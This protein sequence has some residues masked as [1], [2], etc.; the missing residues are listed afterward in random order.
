MPRLPLAPPLMPDEALSSWV[1]RIAA[2]YD[3]YPDVL[4]RHL[5]ANTADTAG[6]VQRLDHQ[7]VPPLEAALVEATGQPADSFAE[8]RFTR[9]MTSPP[10]AW[11]RIKPAW[12]PLCAIRDVAAFGEVYSRG[13]WQLGGVLWCAEHK[14]LLIAECP[15]CFHQVDYQPI[16]GRLRLWCWNCETG[17]D[18]ALK[19]NRIPFW[20]YGT[21]QQRRSC[22]AVTLSDEAPALLLRVQTD[23]LGMLAGKPPR[24]PWSRSLKW[25]RVF[26]VLRRLVFAMLGPLWERTYQVSPIQRTNSGRWSLSETWTPGSLPPEIAAPALLAAVTFLAAESGTRLAGLTWNRQLLIAGEDEAITAETLL[27]HLDT[28]NTGLVRDLFAPRRSRPFALLL[29]A[30]D[31][32]RRGRGPAREATRRRAGLGGAQ[33]REREAGQRRSLTGEML[34]SQR[35]LPLP[36]RNPANRFSFGRLI[37]D[38]APPPAPRKPRE[39]WQEAVAV[40]VVC[41]WEPRNGDILAPQGDWIPDLLRNRYIRLW[42]FRHRHRGA[43]YLITTL[44]DAIDTARDLNRDIVLPEVSAEPIVSPPP[45]KPAVGFPD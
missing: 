24:G 2:R 42:I 31:A 32:D 39:T 45:V 8:H 37:E 40:Y 41:G 7:A 15:R 44:A 16:N 33:R 26:E 3:L 20:P 22:V 9:L 23:I 21:P 13:A 10:A 35:A 18:T 1:A 30:I 5:L 14:C 43:N 17:A 28:F 12:C 25:G 29:A 4:V 27:W 11:P 6:M 34:Q 36:P 38:F 19:P